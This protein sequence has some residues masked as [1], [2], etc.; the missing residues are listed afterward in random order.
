MFRYVVLGLLQSGRPQ[1][2]YALTKA[3]R[4]RIG[5]KVSSGNFYRDLQRLVA[6]GLVRVTDRADADDPR[7][8][9][10]QITEMGKTTFRDWFV[11]ATAVF[12]T[13]GHEDQ[14]AARLAF[15]ADVVPN[16]ARRVLAFFQTELWIMAKSLEHT[17]E[18][19]LSR[20]V[21]KT[22]DFPVLPLM[23]A[24]RLRRVAAELAFLEDLRAAYEE[25]LVARTPVEAVSV[26][27]S[28]RIKPAVRRTAQ[29]RSN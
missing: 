22:T 28:T 10:Y 6:E 25:W 15:L 11:G 18:T 9:P 13:N 16:D 23:L 29:S 2:G 12:T 21:G 8:T 14:L 19:A 7:R 4:D 3:Y 26:A 20:A 5:T 27:P 24:R 17:R 1:H